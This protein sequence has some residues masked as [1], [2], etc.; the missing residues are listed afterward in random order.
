[1]IVFLKFIFWLAIII[2]LV[3]FIHEFGH[4]IAAKLTGIKVEEFAFGFWKSIVSK[5]VGDTLYRVNIIPFGGY[6]KLLGE[7]ESSKDP[8]SFSV[9]PFL[10]R[11]IVIVA[12]VVMNFILAGFIFYIILI[13]KD[14]EIYL[15]RISDYKFLGSNVEI[16]NKPIVENIIED[17][18]ASDAGFPKDVVIWSVDEVEIKDL[19]DLLNY[20][21]EHEGEE[22]AIK[23]LT[24]DGAWQVVRV[25]PSQTGKEGVL[26]GVEF[27]DVIASF[28]KLD[29]G[30][31]K[32]LAGI[33][34]T[35]NFSGYTLDI[36]KELIAISFRERSVEPV[37]E[38]VSGIIGVADRVLD[39][40]KVGDVLEIL[41]LAAGVNLSVAIINLLPIPALDGGFLLFMAI[42]R[43]RG[44][45]MAKKYEEWATKIGLVFLIGLAVLVTVKDVVQFDIIPRIFDWIK[46]LF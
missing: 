36:F 20:L 40:V 15:P 10:T 6:V 22:I 38:G 5:K 12:G 35:L 18:P 13:A 1:M 28:Y 39:L 25:T 16:Q 26:L 24:L 4:F 34:H 21:S 9:K 46:N 37:S 33:L 11:S 32:G 8:K 43:V 31:N 2:G 17:T 44:K 19:D 29:Y 27:Y 23:V 3:I 41:N 14:Y 7:E 42:E 30:R 45:K